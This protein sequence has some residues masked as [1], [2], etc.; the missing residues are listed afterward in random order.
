GG[1][2]H[3][4]AGGM[5]RTRTGTGLAAWLDGRSDDE[6]AALL[7]ARPHL[8]P[9]VPADIR[10][11]A[12]A[13]LARPSLQVA[14]DQLDTFALQVLRTLAGTEESL[15]Y[16]E[17]AESLGAPADGRLRDTVDMLRTRALCFGDDD[18]L[19]APRELRKL[20]MLP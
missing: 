7:T 2:R 12:R 6:I 13:A 11:L 19:T 15:S 14:I 17:L 16:A 20:P 3:R 5:T 4:L 1:G 9:P 10:R 18:A 8:L